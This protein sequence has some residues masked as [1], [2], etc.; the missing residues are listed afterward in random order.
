MTHVTRLMEDPWKHEAKVAS[1]VLI[2]CL[3]L[4]LALLI[5]CT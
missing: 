2:W 3:L 4:A 5:F 1:E